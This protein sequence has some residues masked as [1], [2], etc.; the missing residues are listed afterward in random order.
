[1]FLDRCEC[2]AFLDVIL[3]IVTMAVSPLN[4]LIRALFNNPI[5]LFIV[6]LRGLF[7]Y[8]LVQWDNIES[9]TR[10]VSALCR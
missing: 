3:K 6:V 5:C 10:L 7:V 1:M 8:G 4:E 2:M 9:I